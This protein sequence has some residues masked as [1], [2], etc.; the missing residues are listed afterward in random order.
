[1]SETCTQGYLASIPM[2][3]ASLCLAH[4]AYALLSK[5]VG[6]RLTYP[7]AIVCIS[8]MSGFLPFS[9][10]IGFRSLR[11]LWS[12]FS[13]WQTS[14]SWV[15]VSLALALLPFA[16]M[17]SNLQLYGRSYY[18]RCSTSGSVAPALVPC[19]TWP[20]WLHLTCVHLSNARD[21]LC[22]CLV[23][24]RVCFSPISTLHVT[25]FLK[26]L[27]ALVLP[28]SPVWLSRWLVYLQHWWNHLPYL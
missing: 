9:S 22:G 13:S 21:Y 12:P 11:F 24:L 4:L 5:E 10:Y 1:M 16:S 28:S 2:L 15:F 8:P 27:W 17:Y 14:S 23:F 25:P 19:H 3:Y 26:S 18:G 20:L 7:P 6:P